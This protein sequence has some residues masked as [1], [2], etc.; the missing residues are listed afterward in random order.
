MTAQD[1][2][3][4]LDPF[5]VQGETNGYTATNSISGTRV[6]MAIKDIPVPITVIT[7]QLIEDFSYERVEDAVV[8]DATVTR[9]SRNEANF[10]E[11]FTIRGFRSSL[12]LRNRIPYKGFT[13][14]SMI[15]R[16]EIVKGPAAVLYGL[17]DPGGLVNIITKKPL[18]VKHTSVNFRVGSESNQR[19]EWDTGGPLDNEGKVL[20]RF[21]GSYDQGDHQ[22]AGGW[23]NQRFFTPA[24][25]FLPTD[26]TKIDIEYSRQER[27]H[28]YIRPRNPFVGNG[29]APNDRWQPVSQD[30][31]PITDRDYSSNEGDAW[32]I[33][34]TQTF[35][36][37]MF[38]RATVSDTTKFTDIFNL[39]GCCT[40][41]EDV[42]TGISNVEIRE[43]DNANVYL[44]FNVNFDIGETSHTFLIGAQKDDSDGLTQVYRMNGASG[45]LRAAMMD[46]VPSAPGGYPVTPYNVL[47]DEGRNPDGTAQMNVTREQAQDLAIQ[48]RANGVGGATANQGTPGFTKNESFFI[49][50]QIK[51]MDGKLNV[52]AGVRRD[53]IEQNNLD[54]ITNTS[55]QA[56]FT[57]EVADGLNLYSL[58]SESFVPNGQRVD[59][60]VDPP[61]VLVFDPSEG[62]GIDIGFKF[63]LIEGKLSGSVA[64]FDIDRT[65]ILQG[66]PLPEP[67]ADEPIAFLSGLENSTGYEAQIFYTPTP[68]SQFI[69]SYAHN[70]AKIVESLIPG[71][72]GLRLDQS[73]KNAVSVTGRHSF[74]DTGFFVG[75]NWLYRQGRIQQFSIVRREWA[76]QKGYSTANVF[77]G[78]NTEIAGR[79]H[80]FRLNVQNALDG[81]YYDRTETF[82]LGRR[83]FLSWGFDL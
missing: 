32:S 12:N 63:D 79:N 40:N 27:H 11:N 39:V 7:E 80:T 73:A 69:L 56:G 83:W 10:N 65:N 81:L 82:A 77:A 29:F 17:S 35:S 54:K 28:A 1:E 76:Y 75:G 61:L 66:N 20:F 51:A 9:R 52:L 41:P 26:K 70:D 6:N 47:T 34:L 3:Y 19:V 31:S 25:T 5:T 55:V 59:S 42:F 74:G 45:A 58:Y 43:N 71:A 53:S 14:S 60:R 33:D 78:Y 44:D 64:Y 38:L 16:I 23:H 49:M 22:R 4:T 46:A 37:N 13:D 72:E 68:D 2:T 57:Y 18:N 48:F 36:D 21:T 24:F 8:M 50:D 67:P 62:E 15:D 30:Y